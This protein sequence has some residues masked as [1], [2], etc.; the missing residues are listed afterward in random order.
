MGSRRITACQYSHSDVMLSCWMSVTLPLVC[1][2]PSFLSFFLFLRFDLSWSHLSDL[3]LLST[4]SAST[5][6][7]TF[8]RHL[9]SSS[10]LNLSTWLILFIGTVN[11]D[12]RHCSTPFSPPHL[13]SL[14]H[15][16]PYTCTTTPSLQDRKPI[17][18]TFL[19]TGLCCVFVTS[20]LVYFI[21][22]SSTSSSTSSHPYVYL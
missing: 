21:P 16:P 13:A 20:P 17:S 12:P 14:P 3:L 5:H 11:A 22:R 4:R 2:F 19:V 15:R 10:S 9:F 1:F 8:H 7:F 6:P 18:Q